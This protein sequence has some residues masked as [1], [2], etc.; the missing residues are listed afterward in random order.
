[1]LTLNEYRD[2]FESYARDLL[3]ISNVKREVQ[4]LNFNVLQEKVH[5]LFDRRVKK[6][7]CFAYITKARQTGV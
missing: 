1:M 5:A 3:Y 4:L 6:G 7:R 2:D